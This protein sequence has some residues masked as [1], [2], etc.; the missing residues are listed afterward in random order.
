VTL[1]HHGNVDDGIVRILRKG[2]HVGMGILV[3]PRQILTCAH[4]VRDAVPGPEETI[5]GQIIQVRFPM[6]SAKDSYVAEVGTYLPQDFR[7]GDLAILTLDEDA[8]QGAG[9]ANIAI[10]TNHRLQGKDLFVF[11]SFNKDDPGRQVKARFDAD[12]GR[13]WAQLSVSAQEAGQ[14]MPGYSGG[15][16]WE[17]E[18]RSVVGMISQEARNTGGKLAYFIPAKLMVDDLPAFPHEERRGSDAFQIAFLLTA[19]FLFFFV[20]IHFLAT[21]S[22]G[23]RHTFGWWKDD[24]ILAGF[25][26]MHFYAFLAPLVT[27][28]AWRHAAGFSLHS[29][30]E[31]IPAFNFRSNAANDSTPFGAGAVLLFL[32][33]L[34]A[35]AQGH[36][37]RRTFVKEN[38]IYVHYPTYGLDIEKAPKCQRDFCTHEL[39]GYWSKLPGKW[40]DHTYQIAGNTGAMVDFFPIVQPSILIGLTLVSWGFLIAFLF[41]V[42]RPARAKFL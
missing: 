17:D 9:L 21:Q 36:F 38:G 6:H 37:L 42:V 30:R 14:V 2:E 31:R 24:A 16:V 12:V 4:V 7:R 40:V 29:W 23:A 25:F 35:W 18:T 19:V 15:A 26:G 27:W 34:P 11:A 28:Y 3:S 5:T 10:H 41:A 39:V 8:P 22:S 32:L 1:L 33:V 13:G 20:L